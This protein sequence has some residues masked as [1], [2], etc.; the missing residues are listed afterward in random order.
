[1]IIIYALTIVDCI[2][3]SGSDN[4]VSA[5]STRC[6]KVETRMQKKSADIHIEDTLWRG[7]IDEV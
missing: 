4:S 6:T 7:Q 3:G 5:R 2:S 1:M